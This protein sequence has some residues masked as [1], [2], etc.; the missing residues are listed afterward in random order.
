[1]DLF[2][3]F[4]FW[5]GA[6]LGSFLN[7][8]I[9]RLPRGRSVVFP[10][11][12]CPRCRRPIAFYD[13]LP[14][15]SWL[16]LRGR[17]RSCRRPIS[18]RYLGVE[19]AAACLCAALWM[20]WEPDIYWVLAAVTA[21][22]ALLA[23]TMI[24]WDTFLIPDELSLGLLGAG[25][26]AAPINPFF[27]GSGWLSALLSS[28]AGSL[29]GFTLCWVTAEAGERIFKKEAMGGGDIKLLAAVGAWAGGVGAFDCLLI[30]S[31]LGSIYGVSMIWRG[32]LKRSEPI[33]FG[34]FLSAGAIFNFFWLLPLDF[35]AR[36]TR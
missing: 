34:P 1:M 27:A 24:D 14:I 18:A 21:M 6:C 29:I 36:L 2:I 12:R 16:M 26:L 32:R 13:N 35:L 33:P 23:I 17:C 11:S 20:R 7:V 4:P 10:G 30:G 15:L 22:G 19:M 3:I 28:F 5:L 9:Y 25:W 8:V 31:F